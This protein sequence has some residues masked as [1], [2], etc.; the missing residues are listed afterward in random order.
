MLLL[1][2]LRKMPSLHRPHIEKTKALFQLAFQDELQ[3][4]SYT[5]DE[6]RELWYI[7]RYRYPPKDYQ[8]IFEC[9]GC[10]FSIEIKR[11][12]DFI[13]LNQIQSYDSDMT[14]DHIMNALQLLK[15]A[16]QSKIR[17]C[18]ADSAHLYQEDENGEFKEI[19]ILSTLRKTT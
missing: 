17:F 3:L 14:E 15:S 12:E 8:I 4:E 2:R 1:H 9:E 10:S 16:L 5:K 6:G 19:P 11:D 7:L 13:W 18:K